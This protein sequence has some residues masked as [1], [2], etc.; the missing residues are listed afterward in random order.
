MGHKGL[1]A[2]KCVGFDKRG[3]RRYHGFL[4]QTLL[5]LLLLEILLLLTLLLLL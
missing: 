3:L 1:G 4:A 5:S 2:L